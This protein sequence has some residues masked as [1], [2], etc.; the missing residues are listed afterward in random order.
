MKWSTS[1][2]FYYTNADVKILH[3]TTQGGFA[4]DKDRRRS[5]WFAGVNDVPV[6]R[7]AEFDGT[8]WKIQTNTPI[9]SARRQTAMAHDSD[10]RVMVLFGGD[11]V[12]PSGLGA[13]NDTWELA[14]VDVPVIKGQPF[15][16]YSKAGDTAVFTVAPIETGAP[17][18]Y[19]WYRHPGDQPLGQ[20][21]SG[22]IAGTTSATLALQ[23]LSAADVGE[24][25]VEVS[26]NCGSVLSRRAVLTL[27]RKLVIIAPQSSPILIWPLD[28]KVLLE[29]SLRP[30]GPW[31]VVP[32]PPNPFDISVYG[33]WSFFRLRPVP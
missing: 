6:N 21:P 29:T 33:P 18:K 24:Y 16:Q 8:R 13:T 2:A 14:S 1:A 11:T 15:S 7:M 26:N 5:I 3:G 19:Q 4:F 28:A 22:R 10:R 30:N 23:N 12:I 9:P 17:L 27:D 25:W 32:N 20:D 31:Y